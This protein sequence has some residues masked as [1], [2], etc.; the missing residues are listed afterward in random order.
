M[1]C[2]D[3]IERERE[4]A[5][6]ARMIEPRLAIRLVAAAA[7]YQEVGSPSAPLGFAEKARHVV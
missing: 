7:K 6:V 3:P 4:V 1:L 2:E 5:G